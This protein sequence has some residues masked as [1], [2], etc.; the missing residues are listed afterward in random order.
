M[1]LAVPVTAAL[2]IVVLST[3]ATL[4]R[5]AVMVAMTLVMTL[6]VAAALSVRMRRRLGA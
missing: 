4:G 1:V 6:S 2:A 3:R 5:D